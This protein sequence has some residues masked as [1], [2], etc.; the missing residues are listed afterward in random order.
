MFSRF[1]LFNTKK[2]L[3]LELEKVFGAASLLIQHE[4]TTSESSAWQYMAATSA[5]DQTKHLF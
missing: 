4:G 1:K 2:Y 3:F 5:L